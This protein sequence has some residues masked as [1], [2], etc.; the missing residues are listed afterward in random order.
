MLCYLLAFQDFLLHL[1]FISTMESH[2]TTKIVFPLFG[3]QLLSFD[4]SMKNT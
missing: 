3:L 1:C 2:M 4:C